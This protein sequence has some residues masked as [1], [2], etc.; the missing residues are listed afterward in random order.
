MHATGTEK[1]NG[2]RRRPANTRG[3]RTES[4]KKRKDDRRKGPKGRRKG[5]KGETSGR[6]GTCDKHQPRGEETKQSKKEVKKKLHSR[7][8]D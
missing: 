5:K 1:K 8:A 6:T 3:E 4:S 7:L 2:K